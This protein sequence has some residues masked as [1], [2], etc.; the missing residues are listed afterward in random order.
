MSV[1]S[2]SVVILTYNRKPCLELN[3]A[4]LVNL[5]DEDLEI[6]VVDNG[7]EDGTQ[8]LVAREF[9][10]VRLLRNDRNL[11]AVGR[12]LGLQ[13]A[14]GDI[15]VTLDDDVLGLADQDLAV[16][17]DLFA[18]PELG[19]VCFKVV[20]FSTGEVCNWCH[21]RRAEEDADSRFLTYEIT[22]GAVAFRRAAL[23]AAGLYPVEF[24]ISHE[25]VDLAFRLMNAGYVVEYDSAVTVRHRHE[26]AGRASWRRHY[27]D[28]RNLFW[29]AARNLPFF[30][31]VKYLLRGVV[32]MGVYSLRDGFFW[33]WLRAIC[34]G[35]A[36]LRPALAGRQ[37]W[38][39][40]T[41]ALVREIDARRP[42]IQYLIKKR[43][44]SRKIEL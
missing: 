16:L 15:V 11:G 34:H 14:R 20:H 3:L 6:I 43:L 2:V 12:N 13:A 21:H 10:S 36:G 41:R 38:T 44:F 37:R 18:R 25:G 23:A 32:A 28:T 39:E 9:P 31:A 30:Y 7:S 17:R 24:F 33:H 26:R 22:E 42:R 29:V 19:A 4:S 27:Y 1:A 35:L 40:Q 8:A 5:Q